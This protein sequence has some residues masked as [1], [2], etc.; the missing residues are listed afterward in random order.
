MHGIWGY[1]L[2]VEVKLMK[3]I[4][5][6]KGKNKVNKLWMKK[7]GKQ[8]QV[9]VCCLCTLFL[10]LCGVFLYI[11][12]YFFIFFFLHA[13][14]SHTITQSTISVLLY[15]QWVSLFFSFSTYGSM[16]QPIKFPPSNPIC[17]WRSTLILLY[18]IYRVIFIKTLLLCGFFRRICSCREVFL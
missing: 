5:R 10:F 14:I 16:W 4:F 1:T 9:P 15:L 2:D 12:L 11:I 8:K 6:Q 13:M 7:V 18:G 3:R 17:V